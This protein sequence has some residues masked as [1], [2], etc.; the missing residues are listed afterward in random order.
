MLNFYPG[1]SKLDSGIS[2]YFQEAVASGILEKNH[3]SQDFEALYKEVKALFQHKLLM[4]KNYELLFLSSA[5][6]A[7]EVISQSFV[8]NGSTHFFNGSFGDKWCQYAKKIKP[9]TEGHSFDY[10]GE[11]VIN[12][13]EGTPELIALTHTETSN[14]TY[15]TKS[16]QNEIRIAFPE[17]L[18][19]YDATSSMG[20]IDIN[21]ALG[22]LWFASVQK[23]FGL[24]AGL[25]VL[26]VSPAAIQQAQKV[27]NNSHYNSF[28]FML[29]NARK[30]QTH[31]TPNVANIFLLKKVLENR[32][33]INSVQEKI[34]K[35]SKLI[36]ETVATL[37]NFVALIKDDAV[38]SPTV[39]C[40]KVTEQ[41]ITKVKEEALS[42]DILLGN[43]YGDL[44]ESTI[45]LANFPAI[46]DGDFEHL[47]LFLT[48]FDKM[49]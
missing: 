12:A 5:T 2:Q 40:L 19:A 48:D 49:Y 6:E 42:Q 38:R 46:N 21:W 29:D 30:F 17:S 20:G 3:R 10:G 16:L 34:L 27:G 13:I 28:M 7:W 39:I 4:P 25:G 18:I 45:R 22:D 1:P 36:Y 44:K 47:L 43:G 35:R 33:L 24:P 23:C 9:A 37:E 11:P 31:Y 32:P 15:L 41:L 26:V 8:V 14:G